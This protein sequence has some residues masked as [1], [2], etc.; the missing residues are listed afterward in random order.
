M[1]PLTTVNI[2]LGEDNNPID[3]ENMQ[4]FGPLLSHKPVYRI[5][6]TMPGKTRKNKGKNL[7]RLAT[8]HPIL[9][10]NMFFAAR[11]RCTIT[12]LQ[13]IIIKKRKQ[14][15]ALNKSPNSVHQYQIALVA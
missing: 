2:Q 8:T 13:K 15:E 14:F 4:L 9:A 12:W 10:W 11:A 1:N 7:S 6:A 5:R 3:F